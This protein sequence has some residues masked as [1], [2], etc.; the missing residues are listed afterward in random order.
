[1]PTDWYHARLSSSEL[2]LILRFDP[3]MR[4]DHDPEAKIAELTRWVNSVQSIVD[5]ALEEW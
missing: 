2:D 3:D 5:D 1:M 4:P